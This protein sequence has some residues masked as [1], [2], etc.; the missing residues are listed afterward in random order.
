[1]YGDNVNGEIMARDLAARLIRE[2]RN[3]LLR[4]N[5]MTMKLMKLKKEKGIRC[6][7]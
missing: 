3:L 6:I 5:T 7:S 2:K 1:M 4:F